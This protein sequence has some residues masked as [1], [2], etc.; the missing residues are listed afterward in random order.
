VCRFR[1]FG[2]STTQ[3]TTIT[4]KA[5]INGMKVLIGLDRSGGFGSDSRREYWIAVVLASLFFLFNVWTATAYP[6]PNGDECMIAEPAVNFI[7][8]KGFHVRFSEILAMYSFLLVPWLKVFG[9]SLRSVRSA[10]MACAAMSFLFIWLAVKRLGLISQAALRLCLLL[11]LATEFGMIFAYRTGRYDGFGCLLISLMMLAVSVRETQRRLVVLFFVCLFIPWAGPQYFVALFAGG[12]AFILARG[13][14]YWMEIAVSF[15]AG[16]LGAVAFV[17]AI[18]ISGRLES[19]R[20]FLSIQQRGGS[21]LRELFVRG[22]LVHHNFLPKDFSLP[23]LFIA[24]A[25]LF[26]FLARTRPRPQ[27]TALYIGIAYCLS[28]SVLLILIAKFPTY[29]S[30]LLVIPLSITVISGFSMVGATSIRRATVALCFFSAAAGAGLNL[31][32]YESDAKD[33]Q[34]SLIER[35]VNESIQSDDVVYV[36]SEAYLAAR[37]RAADAYFPNPD[38]DI[39]SRMS[40]EE[41]RSI[42][43]L[44]IEP[45]WITD[46]TRLIGGKWK[47]TGQEL[48]PEGHSI[49]GSDSLGFISWSLKDLKVLRRVSGT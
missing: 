44:V 22:K 13:L 8:G 21:F 29:Y 49:F 2:E 16:A 9:I 47:E 4:L 5:D 39:L 28:L 37:V 18:G 23:F 20:Q 42:T 45:S 36:D 11:L 27:F 48:V 17:C 46:T 31:I 19:Y 38:L 1:F 6:F 33:H 35:F 32:S 41:R 3:Y 15:V 7:Y 14:R 40:L 34:Y 24:A 10:N 25:I 26:L 30:Y 43:V 12:I